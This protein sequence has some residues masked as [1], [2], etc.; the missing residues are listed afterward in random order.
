VA[1]QK[2]NLG[3][4]VTGVGGDKYRDA[5]TKIN[6][7]FTEVDSRLSGLQDGSTSQGVEIT[8]L[9]AKDA[10]QDATIAT[11]ANTSDVNAKNGLQDDAITV[12]QTKDT[13][14]DGAI[15]LRA[16]KTE[17]DSK[18]TLQD[19]AITALQDKDV[20]QDADI[21]L[22]ALKT[23]VDSKNT[24][25]D[26]AINLRAIKSEV[27][28]KNDLQDTAI[29]AAQSKA[30]AAIPKTDKG[31]ANGVATLDV[32][33]KVTPT[34]LPDVTPV[35]W[36]NITGDIAAQTDLSNTYFKIAD[37]NTWEGELNTAIANARKQGDFYATTTT[38]YPNTFIEANG[39]MKRS[40]ATFGTA[41]GKDVGTGAEQ[42]PQNKNLGTAAYKNVGEAA[43]NVMEVGAFG[44]G[45]SPITTKLPSKFGFYGGGGEGFVPHE[46]MVADNSLIY[47]TMMTLVRGAQINTLAFNEGLITLTETNLHTGKLVRHTKAYTTQNTTR[48]ANGFLR[49]SSS[50]AETVVADATG[51][52]A[53]NSIQAGIGAP[54]IAYKKLTGVTAT[55][56][57]VPHGLD[58]SKILSISGSYLNGVAYR[59]STPN[60]DAT[61]IDIKGISSGFSY[62]L[63]ITY[64]VD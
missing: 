42:I 64:E 24:L 14:Q 41:A 52:V 60:W 43:G 27:N 6:D 29:T 4:P 51:N 44:I 22:R 21:S 62:K 19:T 45:S 57:G 33:G 63:L 58:A 18:N 49:V 13:E 7:N 54:K 20:A 53:V 9:K 26:D 59:S 56:N 15:A 2:I 16:L 3:A 34:Q 35:A 61:E 1:I 5:H 23:D 10:S 36:G 31:A 50:I 30:D 28:A 40:T 48:D 8:A 17:V 39:D 25:Q 55:G 11:K 47:G 46:D 38:A 12:L 32:D 37:K